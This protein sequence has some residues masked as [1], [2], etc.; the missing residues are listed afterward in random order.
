M[1]I[2]EDMG[3]IMILQTVSLQNWR[4]FCVKK[5]DVLLNELQIVEVRKMNQ[6]N[7]IKAMETR[8][9]DSQVVFFKSQEEFAKALREGTGAGDEIGFAEELREDE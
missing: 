1:F 9:R 4:F 3:G 8:T 2:D 7:Q 6:T 5:R